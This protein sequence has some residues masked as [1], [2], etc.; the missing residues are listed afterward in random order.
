MSEEIDH[1]QLDTLP[2]AW[3]VLTQADFGHDTEDSEGDPLPEVFA[4]ER[5][6][7]FSDLGILDSD[8]LASI[9]PRRLQSLA[10]KLSHLQRRLCAEQEPGHLTVINDVRVTIWNN[11]SP[12]NVTLRSLES[13]EALPEK[14]DSESEGIRDPNVWIERGSDPLCEAALDRL[15][16]LFDQHTHRGEFPSTPSPKLQA[17]LVRLAGIILEDRHDI[18]RERILHVSPR[19]ELY[20]E[21]QQRAVGCDPVDLAVGENATAA[22]ICV[23]ADEGA[24]GYV[25]RFKTEEKESA[26][27]AKELDERN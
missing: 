19:H 14:K 20:F 16:Q 23:E 18:S 8:T 25:L 17:E 27:I 21:V 2:G 7:Q 15:L 4:A 26:R 10:E 5:K 9:P 24:K 6:Q 1:S 22:D 3:K 11:M 12:I 13:L